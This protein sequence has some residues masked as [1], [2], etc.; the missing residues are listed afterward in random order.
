MIPTPRDD[1]RQPASLDAREHR[2]LLARI[3]AESASRTQF[4]SQF[5]AATGPARVA[6]VGV[7]KG[8][9]AAAMLAACPSI[10][11]YVMV[12]PWR[13]LDEWNKPANVDGNTFEAIH[14]EAM[15]RTEFAASRRRVLRG[16]T[17]E[18]IDDIE[19][20]SL[21]FAYIDGDHTLRGIVTDL[22]AMR[23]KIRPGGWIGGDD[24]C[25]DVWQHG[26]AFEPTLVFP[27]AVHFALAIRATVYALPFD[28]FLIAL[29]NG[30]EPGGGFVDLTGGYPALDLA[31]QVRPSHAPLA[32]RLRAAFSWSRDDHPRVSR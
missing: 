5:L 13:H 6:E 1:A 10:E 27:L 24:F 14:V 11:T 32:D 25:A 16:T 19:D 17:L 18:V 23:D 26:P 4:W 12:D 29:P 9:F 3:A 31:S 8:G 2:A 30:R 21:D 20:A 15:A 28:Q 22:V 7:W